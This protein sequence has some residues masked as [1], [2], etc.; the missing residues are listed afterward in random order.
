MKDEQKPIDLLEGRV[1]RAF[2]AVI[3]YL[4]TR[5]STAFVDNP[6]ALLGRGFQGGTS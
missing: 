1:S 5:L 6:A 4:F 3:Q 2:G